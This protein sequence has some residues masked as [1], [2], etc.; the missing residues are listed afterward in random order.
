MRDVELG[1]WYT[2]EQVVEKMVT[3]AV[4]LE[5][6]LEQVA[7]GR[8]PCER[9][10]GGW[11]ETGV[12]DGFSQYVGAVGQCAAGGVEEQEELPAHRDGRGGECLWF[13]QAR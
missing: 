1:H 4:R 12:V 7:A 2:R 10:D 5:E 11:L 9:Q 6:V 13:E 3:V 8:V